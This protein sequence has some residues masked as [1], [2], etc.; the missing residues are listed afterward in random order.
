MNDTKQPSGE[1]V[2][3]EFEK[4]LRALINKHSMENRSDTPDF[5]LA[6]YV[7]SCLVNFDV[8]VLRRDQWYGRDPFKDTK[9]FEEKKK[10]QE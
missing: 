6:S 3:S 8:A 2:V 1:K 4:E 10:E 9:T 5:I 7:E